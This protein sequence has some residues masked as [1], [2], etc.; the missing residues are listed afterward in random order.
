MEIVPP[1]PGQQHHQRDRD[2]RQA[3]DGE[4]L[5]AGWKQ[6]AKVRKGRPRGCQLAP[7]RFRAGSH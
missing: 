7:G 6:R 2:H 1:P 3:R 5:G 4:R